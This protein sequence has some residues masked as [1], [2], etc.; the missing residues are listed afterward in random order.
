LVDF[1][2]YYFLAMVTHR[3]AGPTLGI[4][5]PREEQ[6]FWHLLNPYISNLFRP[7]NGPANILRAPVHIAD[8]I[9]R[10]S[11]AFERPRCTST[12]FPII[13][14]TCDVMAP[15]IG[16]RPGQMR[17]WPPPYTGPVRT[18][19][20]MMSQKYTFQNSARTDSQIL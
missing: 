6:K 13:P 17:G 7:M 1:F 12:I 4:W 9:R 3:K 8:K 5:A 18:P 20:Y 19:N 16:W 10:R 15:L 14:V 11:F 2:F